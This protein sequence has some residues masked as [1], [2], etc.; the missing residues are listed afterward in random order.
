MNAKLFFF[1]AHV[2]TR[3]APLHDER[4]NAFLAFRRIGI[5]IDDSRIR[6]A[7]V[8]DPRFCAVDDV[9]SVFP[10]RRGTQ[11]RGIRAGLRLGERVAPDAFAARKRH[12]KFFL[13]FFGAKAM[14]RIAVKRILYGKNDAGRGAG[15]RDFFDHDGVTA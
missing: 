12:Q 7:A 1:L 15:A 14:K 9:L 4:G 5:H 3:R 6:D 8:G 13:L 10:D 11:R 2:E